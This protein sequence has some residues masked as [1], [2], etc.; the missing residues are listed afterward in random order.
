MDI[1]GCP[2]GVYI[3]QV[4][5]NPNARL[6]VSCFPSNTDYSKSLCVYAN[7]L[8]SSQLSTGNTCTFPLHC[9][10]VDY[11][12]SIITQHSVLGDMHH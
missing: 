11:M 12:I 3:L 10:G 6:S 2:I 4:L 8:I 1:F 7:L 5:W 9:G